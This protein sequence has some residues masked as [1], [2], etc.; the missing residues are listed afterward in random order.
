[1]S[2]CKDGMRKNHSG[3]GMDRVVMLDVTHYRLGLYSEQ[4]CSRDLVIKGLVTLG[5]M[6]KAW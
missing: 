1:M 2:T 3:F 6:I 5:L 4:E